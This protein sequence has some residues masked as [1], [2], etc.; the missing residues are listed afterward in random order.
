MD[1]KVVLLYPPNQSLPGVM[2]KPNG[3]LAY[4][5][6]A[7]ALMNH[8]IEV[9]IFDACVGNDKDD[10]QNVFYH[11]CELPSGLLRTGVSEERILEEVE[12]ADV[13]GLT[14]I[15]TNQETMVLAAAKLI[16]Q[17]FPEKLIV[18]GGVNARSRWKWFLLNGVDVVCLSEAEKTVVE[19][20]EAV[21]GERDW[22]DVSAIA[23]VHNGRIVETRARADDFFW[24]L[25]ELPLPR[26]DLLPLKR[27]WKIARPHGGHFKPGAELRYASLM[28]TRG[29]LFTC[30]YCHIA[31]ET[32]ESVSGAIGRFRL[33]SD[34]RVLRELAT[35]KG[36]GVEQV[37][38]ED[39]MFLGRKERALRLLSKIQ[40]AGM[41]ISDVNGVN[42]VHL[43]RKDALRR[44]EPDFTIIGALKEA[45][46]REIVLAFESASPRVLRKY[47]TNKWDPERMPINWLIRACK[48]HGLSIGGNY[49]L[50][51]PDETRSEMQ[52]TIDLARQHKEA[53]IDWVTSR[54]SI[55]EVAN[56]SLGFSEDPSQPSATHDAIR[57]SVAGTD[58]GQHVL[59]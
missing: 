22:R 59:G 46:F 35:L 15:F 54:A 23:K 51:Y 29:C 24:N 13:V 17:A 30:T 48:E 8:G 19:I 58:V 18:A 53:G 12:G 40:E 36:L 32:E 26:W 39:D 37:Y 44:Y 10:L 3:S 38:I 31:G 45:G 57:R 33:K 50:G 41:S 49:M 20:V 14:S 4:P 25:D 42:V 55:I 11:S 47:A 34:E 16:K 52:Q 2:C 56:M 5:Y 28:T 1:P 7:G 9:S 43:F 27:Y 21:R 6:L